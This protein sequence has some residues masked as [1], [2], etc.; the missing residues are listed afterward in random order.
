LVKWLLSPHSFLRSVDIAESSG[1]RQRTYNA[2]MGMKGVVFFKNFWG[3]GNQGD[4]IDLWSGYRLAGGEDDYFQ[5]SQEI[6]FWE[7][8]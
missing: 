6:W 3:P 1:G 4:H 8:A 7:L 5:R 2:Y